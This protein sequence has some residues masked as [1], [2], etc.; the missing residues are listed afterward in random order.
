MSQGRMIRVFIADDHPVV[1]DGLKALIFSQSGM[2]VVGEASDGPSAVGEIL[3]TRPD[4]VVM[5]ISM[6]EFSGAEVTTRIKKECPELKVLAL[7]AH[8]DR[9]YLQVMLEAGASGYLLKRAAPDDLV[10]AIETVATGGIYVD[11][12]MA[13][14]AVASVQRK[15]GA[16][17]RS[18]QLSEREAEVLQAL[19]QGHSTKE[20]AARLEVGPRTVETYKARA[21]D[22]LELKNRADIVRYALQRGWL[23]SS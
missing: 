11:P 15:S 7:T 23:R 3:R 19:A 18:G 9:G 5:D 2:D 10:R 16:A 8:E 21:M 6:P 1:R 22:K 13:R 20:I 17:A 12:A 4:V 14:Y